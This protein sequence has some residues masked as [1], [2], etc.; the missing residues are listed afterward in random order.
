M[1]I[2]L[3]CLANYFILTHLKMN[4]STYSLASTIKLNNGL[5]MPRIHLGV[6]LTSGKE[7][8]SAVNHAL[9]AGYRGFD[10]AEWYAN[11]REVG[12]AIGNFLSKHEDVR[13]SD[14]WFT[15]KLKSNSSYD[16]TRKA[17]RESLRKSGLDHI[18]LFLLHSPYGGKAKRLECWRAVED[19][20]DDGEVK[21]GGVSNF[22]IKHVCS[23][24]FQKT[25]SA[26]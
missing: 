22:G 25:P 1:E 9:D 7:T 21:A 15:T 24:F 4:S 2:A 3:L 6:Y 17:I 13:R 5:H 10:S 18:D 16:A 26:K 11:E 20:I 12:R 19:A 23:S 14:I 8:E